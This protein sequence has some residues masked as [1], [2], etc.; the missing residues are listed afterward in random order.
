MSTEWESKY[1][2]CFAW[3]K[4]RLGSDH[5]PILLDSGEGSARKNM[6]FFFER[7]RILELDF[8]E[9]F[10]QAWKEAAMGGAGNSYSVDIW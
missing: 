4:T 8:M 9:V 5:W 7:Q 1:P 2:L 3:S 10:S 6:Y